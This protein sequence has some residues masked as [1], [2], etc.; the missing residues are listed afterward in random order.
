MN[1]RKSL[2]IPLIKATRWLMEEYKPP[3]KR[4][5]AATDWAR[6]SLEEDVDTQLSKSD[7]RDYLEL[8]RSLHWIFI[9]VTNIAFAAS[10]LPKRLINKSTNEEVTSHPMLALFDNPNNLLTNFELFRKTI[11]YHCLVGDAYWFIDRNN[12]DDDDNDEI[13]KI[14]VPRPDRIECKPIDAKGSISYGR[15][16]SSGNIEQWNMKDVVHFS[17]FNPVSDFQGFGSVQAAQQSSILELYTITFGKKYYQNAVLPSMIFKV[18]EML[19]E[20]SYERVLAELQRL[21]V[22]VD[23]FFGVALL[24]AG[25]EPIDM[26]PTSPQDADFQDM[27]ELSRE[28]ILTSLGC[29]HIAALLNGESKS[30]VLTAYRLFY[31]ITLMPLLQNFSDTINK[32]LLSQYD[33]S[34][35]LT[36]EFDLRSAPGLRENIL[37]QSMAD[38][39]YVMTGIKTINEV[40]KERGFGKDLEWGDKPLPSFGLGGEI[41]SRSARMGMQNEERAFFE[42]SAITHPERFSRGSLEESIINQLSDNGNGKMNEDDIAQVVQ[43]MFNREGLYANQ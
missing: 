40:R 1:I 14:H 13:E 8:Y 41:G 39:R 3:R 5:F 24:E 11:S 35:D 22:G 21:H 9:G 36:F 16:R 30:A 23:K 7:L 17:S 6:Y 26:K 25:V 33:D 29:Y 31:E 32:E 4:N 12:T 42:E 2:A 19:D 34:E 15:Q 18:P 43:S 37:D 20:A 10:I 38:Y 27:K 28:E